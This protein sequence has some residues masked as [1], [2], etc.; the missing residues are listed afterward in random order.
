MRP[1][2]RSCTIIAP[3]CDLKKML[4]DYVHLINFTNTDLQPL[5]PTN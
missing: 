2:I 1:W 5:A 3:Y 4:G